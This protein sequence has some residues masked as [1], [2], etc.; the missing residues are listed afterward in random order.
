MSSV[1]SQYGS[2][3]STSFWN[4]LMKCLTSRLLRVRAD[5]R[6]FFIAFVCSSKRLKWKKRL[7]SRGRVA[8]IQHWRAPPN[9]GSLCLFGGTC[10]RA[11]KCH[12]THHIV[13]LIAKTLEARGWEWQILRGSTSTT[14][15]S[16]PMSSSSGV[17]SDSCF[18]HSMGQ[19]SIETLSV[20]LRVTRRSGGLCGWEHC[21]NEKRVVGR[22][23]AF[24]IFCSACGWWHT[25]CPIRD[26]VYFILH[27][28]YA[29]FVYSLFTA[30]YKKNDYTQ[31]S[32]WV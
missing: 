5:F 24:S 27:T 16:S 31:I 4:D 2:S 15:S 23:A 30:L 10:L 12:T 26:I 20:I 14:L 21:R 25:F 18:T 7:S 28:T 6:G 29:F 11:P 9:I 32:L 17:L 22:S 8:T 13:E 3:R 19:N 1:L